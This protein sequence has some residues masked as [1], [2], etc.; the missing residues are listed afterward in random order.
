MSLEIQ[1]PDQLEELVKQLPQHLRENYE[2]ADRQ[3]REFYG[4]APGVTNLLRMWI[5]CGTSSQIRREF[6]L[7]VF[8]V[9]KRQINPNEGGH[10]DED[11]L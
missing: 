2:K 10:F 8:D 4:T 5:A 11:N 1:S 6:E 7:A 3:L 9:T